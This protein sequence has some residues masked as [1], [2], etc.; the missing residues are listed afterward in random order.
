M[1]IVTKVCEQSQEG[2]GFFVYK[3]H[4]DDFLAAEGFGPNEEDWSLVGW[5][6]TRGKAKKLAFK[7][8]RKLAEA[9]VFDT[10]MSVSTIRT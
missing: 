4:I 10:N 9:V 5:R 8:Q 3:A 7:T 1:T 2:R 6:R